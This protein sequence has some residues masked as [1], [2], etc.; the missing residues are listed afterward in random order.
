MLLIVACASPVAPPGDAAVAPASVAPVSLD[1]AAPPPVLPRLGPPLTAH[2]TSGGKAGSSFR[3]ELD[4]KT[5]RGSVWFSTSGAA[6]DRKLKVTGIVGGNTT[7][8]VFAGYPADDLV[9]IH[10]VRRPLP[11]AERLVVGRSV[12]ASLANIGDETRLAFAGAVDFTT[13]ARFARGEERAM[14]CS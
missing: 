14:G 12:I 6:P 1:A 13:D 7:V 5:L 9:N 8:L 10:G 2:C 11:R 4:P 3:I